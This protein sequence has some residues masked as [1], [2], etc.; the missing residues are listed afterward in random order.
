LCVETYCVIAYLVL[1][2]GEYLSG[3]FPWFCLGG[4]E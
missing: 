1:P 2:F 3:A 4:R